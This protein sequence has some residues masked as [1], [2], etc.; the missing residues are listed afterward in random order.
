VL[1]TVRQALPSGRVWL[2]LQVISLARTLAA[3]LSSAL[4]FN[5]VSP[6]LARS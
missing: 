3:R 4:T 6:R 5:A 2:N 1:L